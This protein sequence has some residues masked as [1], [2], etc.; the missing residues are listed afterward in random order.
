MRSWDHRHQVVLHCLQKETGR[1]LKF[2]KISA[3]ML[4]F[5]HFYL[6]QQ[7]KIHFFV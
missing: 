7:F 6:Q 1:S 5:L 4:H 3:V 2:G